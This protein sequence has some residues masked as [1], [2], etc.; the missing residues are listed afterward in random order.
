MA[1]KNLRHLLHDLGHFARLGS[2]GFTFLIFLGRLRR[3]EGFGIERS[4][5]FQHFLVLLMVRVSDGGK[6]IDVAPRSTAIFRWAGPFPFKAQRIFHLGIEWRTALEKNLVPPTVPEVV[7]VYPPGS[8]G[9]LRQQVAQNNLRLVLELHVEI[10][11]VRGRLAVPHAVDLKLVQMVIPPAER[12]L[13]ILMKIG[14]RAIGNLN[15]PPDRRFD[16]EQR[17]PELV[18]KSGLREASSAGLRGHPVQR[19]LRVPPRRT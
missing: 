15:P 4:P 10:V 11:T 12:S 13:D 7:L 2:H 5:P 19:P 3:I 1:K 14:Q 6:I 17:D 16:V 18:Q 8:L 9:R